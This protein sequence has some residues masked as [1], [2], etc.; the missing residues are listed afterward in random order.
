MTDL[1]AVLAQLAECRSAGELVVPEPLGKSFLSAVGVAV[2]HGTLVERYDDIPDLVTTVEPP[3]AVKAVAA[4]VRHK[5]DVGGVQGPIA[6]PSAVAD[7]VRRTWRAFG[8]PVLVERWHGTGVECFVGLSVRGPYGPVVS[9]GLGGVWVEVLRDVVHRSAPV[10]VHETRELLDTLRAAPLLRGERGQPGV[11]VAALTD[12]IS[13]LSRL[14][15]DA[16]V[17]AVVDEVEVNPLSAQ[18]FGPPVALDCSLTLA[19]CA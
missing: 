19:A 18:E 4:G 14:A 2:P 1:H 13:A 17:T 9:V 10:D 3:V 15:G 7:A 6:E 12:T 8:G 11:D 5:S 16:E